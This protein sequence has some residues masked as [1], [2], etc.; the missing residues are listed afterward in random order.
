MGQD[1]T[2]ALAAAGGDAAAFALLVRRHQSDVRGLLRRLT[3]GD[4][5]LADDL[6]QDTFLEAQRKIGQFTG[7]GR[8]SSW[9]YAIAWS[10]FRMEWRKRRLEPLDDVEVAAPDAGSAARLD[11]EKAMVKLAPAERAALTLCFALGQ[12]HEEAAL[13]MQVPL[14]TLKS[15]VARGRERLKTLLAGWEP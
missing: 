5:A 15:N 10:R 2:L 4:A 12:S 7:R 11:L 6:A 8:F 9:L 13:T 1:E 14:G 3:R